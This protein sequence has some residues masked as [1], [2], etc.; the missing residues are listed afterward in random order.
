MPDPIV[1]KRLG[2]TVEAIKSR[3]NNKGI[4]CYHPMRRWTK[5]EDRILLSCAHEQEA[6]QRLDRPV[7]AIQYR[8]KQLRTG[9]VGR[10]PRPWTPREIACLGKDSDVAVGRKLRRTFGAVHGK[11]IE[12]G[13]LSHWARIR[14]RRGR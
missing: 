13:I 5:A 1:A 4:P 11:R 12:M 3:R 14:R 6:A 7:D 2:R 8:R 9:A 10:R